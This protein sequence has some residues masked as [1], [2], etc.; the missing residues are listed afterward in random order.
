[1]PAKAHGLSQ[2]SPAREKQ[3]GQGCA[4][5]SSTTALRDG[6]D[7][8]ARQAR[9]TIGE[10]ES[11]MVLTRQ[12]ATWCSKGQGAPIRSTSERE[13]G[14]IIRDGVHAV[15]STAFLIE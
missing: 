4:S 12:A 6:T 2:I 8:V 3:P 10:A 11:H 15:P 14:S 13:N 5:P 9:L 1:M 7:T